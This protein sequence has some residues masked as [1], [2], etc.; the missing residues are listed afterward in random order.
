MDASQRIK[1]ANLL[2]GESHEYA[3]TRPTVWFESITRGPIRPS[4]N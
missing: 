4:R 2:T 1:R 3:Y